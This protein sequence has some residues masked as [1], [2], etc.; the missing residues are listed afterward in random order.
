MWEGGDLARRD[1]FPL[2]ADSTL[3]LSCSGIE[4]ASR[5][6]RPPYPCLVPHAA[7]SFFV[8]YRPLTARY[9]LAVAALPNNCIQQLPQGGWLP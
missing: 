9:Y 6:A 8:P 7:P 3:R 2:R 1:L 4:L 5:W